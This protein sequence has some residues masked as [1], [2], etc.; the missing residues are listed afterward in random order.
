MQLTLGSLFDGIGGFPYAAELSGIKPVWASEIEPFPIA[1]TK[2][3]FPDMLHLG[4]VTDIN[5]A[6]IPPVDI[7]TF[8]SPCQD[9][10]VAGQRAGLDG[11]RSGLFSEA[12]RI[13]YEMRK[14]TN[15]R[16]PT[17]AVWENVPGAF[18]SN[19]GRDFRTVL[20]EIT[21]TDIP[22]PRSGRW[23][24][25]GV[26]RGGAVCAAW[27]VLDAQYWGVP[28]RR[29]RIFLIASFGNDS[30]EEI[31]FKP[32]SV[33]RYLEKSG[34]QRERAATDTET[35]IDRPV[36]VML[37]QHPND[38]RIKIDNSGNCQTLTTRMGTGG[39]NVPLVMEQKVFCKGTRP[40][41]KDEAQEWKQTETANTLNTFDIGES[42][43]N[44]IVC[45]PIAADIYNNTITDNVAATLTTATGQGAQNTGPSAIIPLVVLNDQGGNMINV[46]K[47][48]KAPTL[49]AQTHGNEPVV[50]YPLNEQIVTRYKAL[51]RG[52]GLG[53]G[54]KDDPAFTL[55]SAHPH[56]IC[57]PILSFEPG[58]QSR[59]GSHTSEDVSPTLRANMGDNQ[60]SVCCPTYCI[61]GN[62]I[63]RSDTA[64]ANGKGVNEDV[65]YTLNTADRHAV[66]YRICSY[67]SNCMKSDN[68]NSG[69]YEADKAPTLDLNGGN[70]A[71]NQGGL[72]VCCPI[73]AI[74]RAAFNQGA[75]AKYNIEISDKGIN[76]TVVAKG[77]GAVCV[78]AYA[79]R[80]RQGCAGGGKG[81]LFQTEKTGTIACNNDQTV[82]VPS[83]VAR[84]LGVGAHSIYHSS[85]A[86]YHTN[87]TDDSATDTLLAT[88]YKDP[89]IVLEG[90]YYIVR[91]LTP[92]ECERL[93][94]YPD[95]WTNLPEID[96]MSD[97]ETEF[98]QSVIKL[99]K[100]ING[101]QYKPVKDMAK[102][103]NKLQTDGARY[104][105]L[106][107]SLAIPCALRVISGIAEY[108]KGVNR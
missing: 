30:A 84:G 99:H 29:K 32:D 87:F 16:Y 35:G 68:P 36:Y 57:A 28:Q 53:V 75:N 58:A 80:E 72:M 43:C 47:E 3:R 78:P 85:K 88:D 93:Q 40:H 70:P 60:V 62:T 42:R 64:G 69:I 54:D 90:P 50:C 73:Y 9:L 82:F 77:P 38:S 22:M 48:E 4:S 65:S 63:D 31:L 89:P 108:V 26:V 101:K 45:E 103:R 67:A 100:Q 23:A 91:R 74:D 44:E 11:E 107:N 20:E 83:I 15:G 71:C 37:K 21:K 8:G 24:S 56:M 104:K 34:T 66:C 61:Q 46:E 96:S 12:V 105:A 81:P 86:S 1:V 106:G 39:G 13:I 52:T 92:L 49:R 25:A 97:A 51:G 102:W 55:Q 94:G 27:R 2:Q 98:W 59:V 33:R 76:S 18:S 5:G 17:Y 79:M 95:G 14:A 7:I 19:K 10:S 41:N 6:D